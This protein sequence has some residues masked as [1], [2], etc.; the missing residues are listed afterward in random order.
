MIQFHGPFHAVHSHTLDAS[1]LTLLTC[2]AAWHYIRIAHCHSL[3]DFT[4]SSSPSKVS[5]WLKKKHDTAFCHQLGW[6][7][8]YGQSGA[9]RISMV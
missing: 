5:R 3:S 1:A 9:I 6:Q 4:Y 2:Q 8:E 7:L